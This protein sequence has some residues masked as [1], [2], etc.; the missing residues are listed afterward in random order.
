MKS[1][2]LVAAIGASI[3]Q[4]GC[5]AT[6]TQLMDGGRI[7]EVPPDDA[8]P[9]RPPPDS[10]GLGLPTHLADDPLVADRQ[11]E[12]QR[13]EFTHEVNLWPL[14]ES[15]H[16]PTGEWRT[17]FWPFFHVTTRPDGEV[18]SWHVLNFLSGRRYS[19]FLPFYYSVDDDLGIVPPLF[20]MGKDYW[21]TAPLL[22]GRWAYSD[23]DQTTWVTPLFHE[24]DGPD[25]RLK[26]LHAGFYFEGASGWTLPPLLTG[27]ITFEDGAH[28]LWITPLFHYSTD[29]RGVDDP[30][31]GL[32]TSMHAGPF[33]LGTDY[34]LAL[35]LAGGGT[36]ADGGSTLWIT[37]LFHVSQDK[38]GHLASFHALAYFKGD[39]WWTIPPLLLAGWGKED[40]YRVTMG[41]FFCLHYDAKGLV[42][43]SL[44]PVYSWVRDESWC[45]F[46]LLSGQRRSPDKSLVTW[47]TPLFHLTND[48]AGEPESWH[49]GPYFAGRDYWAVPPLFAWDVTY[50][51]GVDALWLTPL[52]HLTRN[53]EGRAESSHLLPVYFWE[54]DDYWLAPPLLAA[55]WKAQNGDRTLWATPFFHWTTDSDGI[56]HS[57][58]LGPYLQGDTYWGIP[59]LMTGGWHG[60]EGG[61]TT[62]VTPF[63]HVTTD[64]KGDVESLHA[65]PYFQGSN[66]WAVPPLFS[67]HVRFPDRVETTWITPAFHVTVDPGGELTSAHLFPVAFWERDEYWFIPP[68]LTGSGRHAD[69]S[70]TTWV[71]PLFHATEKPEGTLESLHI[72]PLCFWKEDSYWVLPPLLSG[73]GTHSDGAHT[74]WITPIFHRTED[75][76]GV[77][78]SSHVFPAWFWKRDEYWAVPPLLTAGV[79]RPDGSHTTWISPLYHE[80]Y[81]ADGTLR[82]RHIANY[83]DGATY[84]HV[85]PVFWDWQAQ[86]QT[87]HTLF[88]PP[89]F[90]R[91][92]EANGDVTS[93]LPWPIVTW[94]A[95][96]ELDTSLGMELR[97]FLAQCAGDRY[98]FNFLWRMVSVLHEEESTRV[99]IGPFWHSTKPDR[100]DTPMKFQILGGLFARDCNYDT[101]RYR[102]RLLWVIPLGAR[103]MN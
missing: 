56:L 99:F 82:S 95:G 11:Q 40:D 48:T 66:Y 24:T 58:H 29:S 64:G 73:G 17:A 94:R 43:T 69:G 62:W 27:R 92:E 38:N 16:L 15:T 90:V 45:V 8:T 72:A 59:P 3:V 68:L 39:D 84:T 65:G 10:A 19:M 63:F 67:W 28:T 83:F 100:E 57:M 4:A 14:I 32:F 50:A 102:Y 47:I 36:H 85:L 101:Q 86:D 78:E 49:L 9:P 54:R 30:S 42:S 93:S 74:A 89:I 98:E 52:F 55:G 5:T 35:P 91:T 61:N 26:N 75:K 88:A 12:D 37:P 77:L 7:P 53:K 87:H 81:A 97:P 22:T 20:L 51:D 41:L 21:L 71:T 6:P 103:S 70:Q 13:N 44:C 34:W 2:L 60:A 96:K 18:H 33:F 1:L 23:G 46:P 79:T 25:G 31:L 80:D 76:N